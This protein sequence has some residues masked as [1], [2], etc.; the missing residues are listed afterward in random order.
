MRPRKVAPPP[1]RPPAGART[2]ADGVDAVPDALA[3]TWADQPS[4]GREAALVRV[5]RA[6][7]EALAR[8]IVRVLQADAEQVSCGPS[9]CAGRQWRR[10]A[11]SWMR[12]SP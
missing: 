1:D 11:A 6:L 12:T 7:V 10:V 2:N 8:A 5:E 4:T 3:D 9:S